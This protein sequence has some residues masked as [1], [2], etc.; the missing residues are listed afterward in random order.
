M[1]I[2]LVYSIL[3]KL[4]NVYGFMLCNYS[5]T[6][7]VALIFKAVKFIIYLK[8]EVSYPV[9]IILAFLEYFFLV[10]TYFWLITMSFYMWRT[11][12][13]FSSL[14][15]NIGRSGNKKL[16]YYVIF[17]YGC[18]L[19]L[20]IVCVIIVEF[21]SE[22]IPKILRAE[23]ERGNCWFNAENKG[24]YVLYFY[25]IETACTISSV[26]LSISTTLNIKRCEKDANFHLTNSES[27]R[28][29]DNK[30]WFNLYMKL[31]ML[32]FIMMG[33]NWSILTTS[34]WFAYLTDYYYYITCVSG[35]LDVVQSFCTFII[36]VWKKKIKFML[37]KRF[38]FDTTRKIDLNTISEES[39]RTSQTFAMTKT[40]TRQIRLMGLN[41]NVTEC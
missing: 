37:L 7:S 35:L 6:S 25:W 20:A 4:R 18:P 31:F 28:Y 16:I 11:F 13:E 33:I 14:R 9:C 30:I 36:F 23:L 32:M 40:V 38:G 19:I 41:S 12:R 17:A 39:M 2:F 15:K 24:A 34:W 5:F 3:P 26:C 29:N 8:M 22:Y 27:K 1:P 10:S 21:V